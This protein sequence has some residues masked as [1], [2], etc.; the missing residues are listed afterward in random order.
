MSQPMEMEIEEQ[1]SYFIV[2]ANALKI[3]VSF[4]KSELILHYG[5]KS[6]MY[7]FI[8]SKY[9]RSYFELIKRMGLGRYNENT[10]YL[11]LN[12]NNEIIIKILFE[13]DLKLTSQ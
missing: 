1:I 8:A 2:K 5:K 3:P 10:Q 7:G 12:P 9:L 13:N 6:L 11:E 4:I